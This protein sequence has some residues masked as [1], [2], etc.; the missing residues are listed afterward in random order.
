[1]VGMSAFTEMAA[2]ALYCQILHHGSTIT[3]LMR[4]IEG[5]AKSEA[6][7]YA[8]CLVIH[9]QS[10]VDTGRAFNQAPNSFLLAARRRAWDPASEVSSSKA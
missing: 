1:M 8:G 7:S 9:M 5:C 3:A 10:Q 6:Y 4:T 2:E